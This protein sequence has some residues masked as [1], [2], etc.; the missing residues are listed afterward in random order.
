MVYDYFSR[1]QHVRWSSLAGMTLLLVILTMR[2]TYREDISAFLPLGTEEREMLNIYQSISGA[3]N[4]IVVFDTG[5]DADKTVEAI[6]AFRENLFK[7]DAEGWTKGMTMQ[8]DM[9][10]VKAIQDFAYEN[11]PYFLTNAD[12]ARMDS[13]LCHPNAI[14]SLLEHDKQILMMPTGSMLSTVI[15][16]DPLNIF[17]PV[18]SRLQDMQPEANLEIYDGH[19]FTPD[20][21][22][23]IAILSSPFGNAETDQNARLINLINDAISA[24]QKQHP[25]TKAHVTGGPT[26]AVGNAQQIKKDS[27]VAIALAVVL[28]AALLAWSI[29]SMRNILLIALTTGWGW[30]FALGGMA[31]LSN[32]VSIIVLGMS[33]VILGIAVNYPLHLVTHS[34]HETDMRQALRDISKPLLVG[35]IT[36]VGAFLALVPLKSTAL[37]DLGLFAS[38]LLAGTIVF[39][40]I[41]LPHAV[42]TKTEAKTGMKATWLERIASTNPEK[43]RWLVAAAVA[44]TVVFGWFSL[45]T[46]FDPDMASIN[47]MT[48][49]QRSDMDYINRMTARDTT[50]QSET[51]YVVS[52]GN[53]IDEA[54]DSALARGLNQTSHFITSKHEQAE[55]LRKWEDFKKRHPMLTDGTLFFT[56]KQKG[57][58]ED[59]FSPFYSIMHRKRS[60]QPFEYFAPLT[61]TVFAKSISIDKD[62][63]G[64]RYHV[65][66][67]LTTDD[68][69]AQ[70][71]S[72]TFT[73]KSISS[74]V[75]S[76]LSSNFNYIGVACSA[77]VFLFLWLSFRSLRTAII[78]FVPMAVSW[79]WILGIMAMLGIKFNIV[80]I[81]LA[82][83]IFGQGDDYTIFV[84]EGCLYERQTGRRVLAEYKRSILISAMIM[85][86]GI[87]TLI[88]AK[89]PALH[90]L[91]EVTIIGMACVVFMAW[92]VPPLLI[93][94]CFKNKHL[95]EA[96]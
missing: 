7:A 54:L 41:Y 9:E 12:Y 89:H 35:N 36:T 8:T 74:A 22:Y 83:F 31:L 91:A 72:G 48:E 23:A 64:M 73:A 28:I 92:T 75:A 87:G 82:T 71:I 50:K 46:E 16:R 17:T 67:R 20:M 85:F 18:V 27:A 4:I 81:I 19:I 47:Y 29:R 21:K 66:D 79:I 52:S 68:P 53:T 63:G 13:A 90:S 10:T 3:E 88:F 94:I 65:I 37:R 43:K 58:A 42:K 70:G 38:L 15:S 45:K 40:L 49:E 95:Q 77:I 55:R 57:F 11:I 14:D 2:L 32:E 30:L 76:T 84:T 26:I 33:S 61:N 93:N 25:T 5:G 80:N 62:S 86:V 24:T 44:L 1:H 39:V 60:L 56:A 6:E 69:R 34:Q 59:A 78:A 96:S 51:L